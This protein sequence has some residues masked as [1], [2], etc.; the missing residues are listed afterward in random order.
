MTHQSYSYVV[1]RY[2]PDQGAGEG[3][4]VGVIIYS[5]QAR[6]FGHRI[7]SRYER[8]SRAFAKFDG[9]AFRRATANLENVFS[10]AERSFSEKP[11]LAGDRSFSEWLRALMPDTGGSFSFTS[12]RH[13]ITDDLQDE[14]AV[15]FD[16][17]VESQKGQ[18]DESPR[19][20]DEQVW[21]S[22]ERVLPP[23]VSKH[24]K[25]KSFSTPT[26][27]VEFEHAMKNG[28]WHVI[29]PISMDFKQPESMQRKASQWVGTA[30]GLQE[31]SD[32]GTIFFLL[33]EPAGHR[34]AYDRAKALLNQ[35][36]INHEIVEERDADQ[37]GRRLLALMEHQTE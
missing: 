4:N 20:D 15:L 10:T 26:V 9:P 3:L 36:P 1:L 28:A 37:F 25:R 19:R 24:L 27:E 33:G 22:Y 17:M 30:V 31:A 29:Q 6:F 35:A 13:G 14:V 16:R 11:L 12:P 7:D 8:L 18:T 5:E 32:L 34:R 21:R 2:V 23:A